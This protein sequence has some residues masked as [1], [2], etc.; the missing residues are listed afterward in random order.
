DRRPT[1]PNDRLLAG[2]PQVRVGLRLERRRAV[3]P[4]AEPRMVIARLP[5]PRRQ[6]AD[7]AERTPTHQMFS[8]SRRTPAPYCAVGSPSGAAKTAGLIPWRGRAIPVHPLKVVFTAGWPSCVVAAASNVNARVI[9]RIIPEPALQL[10]V[11]VPWLRQTAARIPSL[12][13]PR[14][15]G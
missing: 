6:P 13:Q 14:H 1:R 8:A 3:H 12:D 10:P 5:S 2:K 7:Q 9:S 4:L 15:T 11:R